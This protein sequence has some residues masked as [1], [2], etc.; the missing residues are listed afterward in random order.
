MW[1]RALAFIIDLF[2]LGIITL[3][4]NLLNIQDLDIVSFINLI[5]V[6]SYFAG[7]DYRYGG[8]LGKRWL[9]LRVA[10]PQSPQVFNKLLLRA[11]VKIVSIFPPIMQVY[12]LIAIWG[13]DGRSL[14]DFASGSTVID[15]NTQ[16]PPERPSLAGKIMA[17]FLIL[18]G[19]L[20]A[21]LIC[22][23]LFYGVVT[24][25]VILANWEQ[26]KDSF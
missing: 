19:P 6:V 8:T 15:L 11:V 16:A 9:G 17:S 26:I 13:D 1:R 2:P 22:M 20:I 12:G 24:G 7:M 4:E 18:F 3:V 10:L 23:A 14:A 25:V 21:L 5:L